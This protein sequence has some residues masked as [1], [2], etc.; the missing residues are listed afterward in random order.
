MMA[1]MEVK[2]VDYANQTPLKYYWIIYHSSWSV[3]IDN[4]CRAE[5][6]LE[7]AILLT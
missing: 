3:I 2:C 1:T 5:V 7:I 4:C 6:L